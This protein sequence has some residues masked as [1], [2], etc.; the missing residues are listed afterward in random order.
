[1]LE[2][3]QRG[4]VARNHW[5][6]YSRSKEQPADARSDYGERGVSRRNFDRLNCVYE[7]TEF[8]CGDGNGR[9][10]SAFAPVTLFGVVCAVI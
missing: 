4:C 3:L 7:D 2:E 8:P 9:G 10:P 5:V 1:M 6:L